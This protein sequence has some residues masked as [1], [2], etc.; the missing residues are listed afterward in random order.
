[1]RHGWWRS[2]VAVWATLV[3]VAAAVVGVAP[4]A[5]AEP[6]PIERIGGADR[7]ET[8]VAL[9]RATFPAGV[10]R[11]Y[12]AGGDSAFDALAVAPIAGRY[13]APVLLVPRDGVPAA[14]GTELARLAPTSLVVIGGT[15]AVPDAVVAQL[16]HSTSATIARVG[17]ADRY[18]T[19]ALLAG[20][21]RPGVRTVFVASGETPGDALAAGPA[22]AAAASPLLLVTRAGVPAATAATLTRLR[23]S[24]VR[25]IGGEDV[26]P[27]AVMDAAGAA[28]GLPVVDLGFA[29]FRQGVER[30]AG[31]DRYVTSTQIV[32]QPFNSGQTMYLASGDV[33]TDALVAGP[34]ASRSGG[35]LLLTRR[36][37]LPPS[38][39]SILDGYRPVR[40]VAVGGDAAIGQ[41]VLDRRSCAAPLS[42]GGGPT[43]TV[44]PSENLGQG[45]GVTVTGAGFPPGVGVA[46]VQ[47]NNDPALPPTGAGCFL[48]GYSTAQVAPDGTVGPLRVTIRTGALNADPAAVCPPTPEQ[49]ARGVVCIIAV[50]TLDASVAAS[51]PISFRPVPPPPALDVSPD[52]GLTDAQVVGV[53]GRGFE[54]GKVVTVMQCSGRNESA[55]PVYVNRAGCENP[56]GVVVAIAPDGTLPPT[57]LV[58]RAGPL[59]GNPMASCPPTPLQIA[60]G[61]TACTVV[62]EQD[63]R[64][65]AQHPI[66]F[67]APAAGAPTIDV[68]PR[69]GLREGARVTVVADGLPPYTPV[70]VALC[71]P[72]LFSPLDGVGYGCVN[73]VF[74]SSDQ[75]GHVGPVDLAVHLSSADSPYGCPPTP[76]Q[77]AAGIAACVVT[78]GPIG[79]A[80]AGVPVAFAPDVVAPP[81][82]GVPGGVVID[83]VDPVGEAVVLRNAT[84]STV[85]V[86]G[87]S[88]VDLAGNLVT[89]P[90]GTTI[91]PGATYTVHPPSP[92]LDDGFDVVTL[93]DARGTPVMSRAWS[94]PPA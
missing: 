57:S 17:G 44:T 93:L 69:T 8:A 79:G 65:V 25:V 60:A 80:I 83:S 47:C 1:M 64:A 3:A 70:S 51:A 56:R 27:P 39:L 19:A 75:D 63:G 84:A 38:T 88:I 21:D 18:E 14:V 28:A 4:P 24:S 73:G 81:P 49:A 13:G 30:V 78:V 48:G 86:S 53:S 62:V 7:Y 5:G 72:A 76:Q 87:W 12:V 37:C 6:A 54:P 90:A 61:I 34:A 15:N 33:I 59:T 67:A 41:G 89:I 46:A 42:G 36:D 45:D 23:P 31:P 29:R 66:A 82:P 9:S 52:A 10:T 16:Q 11:A 85:D 58:L 68:T 77:V 43:V 35:S 74:L 26:V 71:N 32:A 55:F 2:V 40:V 94:V 20:D 50:A 91:A 22:A 92:I